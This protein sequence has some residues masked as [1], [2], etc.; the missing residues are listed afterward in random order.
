M[1]YTHEGVW[2]DAC[3]SISNLLKDDHVKNLWPSVIG[4]P[5]EV[6]KQLIEWVRNSYENWT[7]PEN[8]SLEEQF[9]SYIW[10]DLVETPL[11]PRFLIR[12]LSYDLRGNMT[13]T[14]DLTDLCCAGHLAWEDDLVEEASFR[15]QHETLTSGK[16]IVIP[17]GPSD[18]A[19]IKKCLEIG[20]PDV[21]HQFSFLNF[22]SNGAPGGT[23][24]V[25]SLTRGL[26]GA[27]VMNRV[28]ALLDNDSA[29]RDAQRILM[30]SSLPP[31][32]GVMRLPDVEFAYSYPTLGP[33][34]AAKEDVNGRAVSVEFMLGPESMMKANDGKLPPVRWR[35]YLSSIGDYQGSLEI[36]GPVQRAI[37]DDLKTPRNLSFE[38]RRTIRKLANGMVELASHL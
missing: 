28:L 11:D 27:G 36:K 4:P 25:V 18:S 21:A 1:G 10:E 17:E 32:F 14:L 12:L 37:M 22:E 7:L 24:R 33:S 19:I 9:L 16:I 30:D 38:A 2:N 3:A 34:G 13:V 8:Q 6:L 31:H 23:D 26:A 29:G 15:M 20:R 35:S 5:E